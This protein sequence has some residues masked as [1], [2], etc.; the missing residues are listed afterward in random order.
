M[1]ARTVLVRRMSCEED[2]CTPPA[3]KSKVEQDRKGLLPSR[4][5]SDRL[6]EDLHHCLPVSLSVLLYVRKECDEVFDA[7]MLQSPTLKA[8]MEAVRM[9]VYWLNRDM[10]YMVTLC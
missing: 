8:L 6:T 3:K 10:K 2:A 9:S 5:S 4:K 1:F 7:L